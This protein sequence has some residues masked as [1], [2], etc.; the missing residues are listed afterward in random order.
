MLTMRPGGRLVTLTGPGGAG[1]TRL[2]LAVAGPVWS[3]SR[4]VTVSA[5]LHQLFNGDR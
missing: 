4:R 3:V 5:G 2:A 1:K